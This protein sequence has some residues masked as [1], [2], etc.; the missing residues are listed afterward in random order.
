[1]KPALE[2]VLSCEC[3]GGLRAVGAERTRI[4]VSIGV[5]A[6]DRASVFIDLV[7]K[8]RKKQAAVKTGIEGA[9]TG[10][11]LFCL[12]F[13][14]SDPFEQGGPDFFSFA[15]DF[16]Q[17]TTGQ[18]RLQGDPCLF[19]GDEG[20]GEA[21][22]NPVDIG[23]ECKHDPTPEGFKAHGGSVE[24]RG[25][26]KPE[27]PG[28]AA[29]MISGSPGENRPVFR[30]GDRVTSIKIQPNPDRQGFRSG[31]DKQRP[32]FGG[33]HLKGH[34]ISELGRLQAIGLKQCP[35]DPVGG[36]LEL[37][38]DMKRPMEGRDHQI[39]IIPHPR[40]GL[41]G[42]PHSLKFGVVWVEIKGGACGRLQ[43]P[44]MHPPGSGNERKRIAGGKIVDGT[45]ALKEINQW[46]GIHN[47]TI[48]GKCWP[49]DWK[50]QVQPFYKSNQCGAPSWDHQFQLVNSRWDGHA[51][52][53]AVTLQRLKIAAIDTYPADARMP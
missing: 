53:V 7:Q 45:G 22:F 30:F 14:Q 15:G 51:Q 49:N 20:P 5:A 2:D 38:F 41:M 36:G 28:H 32:P 33:T 29:I 27:I 21:E 4:D 9:C 31:E 43:R 11:L 10:L 17:I 23:R 40:A 1:M 48:D 25:E 37:R 19:L 50:R 44:M 35:V 3:S 42:E 16:I 26:S 24:G 46:E 12:G 52:A 47:H 13:W 34:P 8:T 6:V 18:F 39:A